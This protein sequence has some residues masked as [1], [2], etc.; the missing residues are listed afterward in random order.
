MS[1][2]DYGRKQLAKGKPV[3]SLFELVAS[4]TAG[5]LRLRAIGVLLIAVGLVV[6]TAGNLAAL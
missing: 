6:S 1:D 5:N 4:K 2:P 3:T